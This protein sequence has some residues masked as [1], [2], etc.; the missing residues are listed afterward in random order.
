[1][2]KN[3]LLFLCLIA[4]QAMAQEEKL[5]VNFNSKEF[6]SS[7]IPSVNLNVN[8]IKEISFVEEHSPLDIEG[9]WFDDEED[10][11]QSLTFFEDGSVIHNYYYKNIPLYGSEKGIY[12]YQ[13]DIF[14]IGLQLWGEVLCIPVIR[15]TENSFTWR[16]SGKNLTYYKIQKVYKMKIDD[17]PITIGNDGDLIVYSDN[18]FVGLKDNRVKALQ[19]GS[20]F[21]LVEDAKLHETVAYRIDVEKNNE[22]IDWTLYFK[23]PKEDIVAEFGELFRED[24]GWI[25]FTGEDKSVFKYLAF[26]F[27]DTTETVKSVSVT[28][29]QPEDLQAYSD[30]ID[31]NYILYESESSS[32]RK[33]YY[34][35]EKGIK[36]SVMIIVDTSTFLMNISYTDRNIK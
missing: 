21:V 28:F 6:H 20:G 32:S 23:K 13:Y 24:S 27:D 29:N 35:T 2:R 10:V 22:I 31:Q 9:E 1:M 14:E 18:V 19:V 33:V 36:S 4:V 11:F 7:E 8:D 12:L 17:A 34:D 16:Y 30:F 5:R 25:T 26:L 15:H 3:V